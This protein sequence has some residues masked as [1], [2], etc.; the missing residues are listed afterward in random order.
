M[1]I[2]ENTVVIKRSIPHM[3][4]GSR[5]Q[6]IGRQEISHQSPGIAVVPQCSPDKEKPVEL[7]GGPEVQDFQIKQVSPPQ[8][9][10]FVQV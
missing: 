5:T 4:N 7:V 3:Q 10:R 1:I 8:I 6:R 2:L 9:G